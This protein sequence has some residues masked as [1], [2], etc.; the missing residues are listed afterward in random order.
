[1]ILKSREPLDHNKDAVHSSHISAAT[2]PRGA[3]EYLCLRN[4]PWDPISHEGRLISLAGPSLC[5][6]RKS[7]AEARQTVIP[8]LRGFCLGNFD[9]NMKL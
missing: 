4:P 2:I 7:K 3:S 5:R 9:P 8:F 1:M 6:L